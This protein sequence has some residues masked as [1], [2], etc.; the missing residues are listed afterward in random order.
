M[1]RLKIKLLTKLEFLCIDISSFINRI[2]IWAKGKR[3]EIQD[4]E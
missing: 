3:W 4:D 1:V 2:G